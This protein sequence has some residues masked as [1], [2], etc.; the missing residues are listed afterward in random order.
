MEKDTHTRQ[1]ASQYRLKIILFSI[2]A[3]AIVF[4]A[5]LFGAYSYPRNIWTLDL[6]GI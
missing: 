2:L 1:E 5:Y 3:I 6:K 4:S